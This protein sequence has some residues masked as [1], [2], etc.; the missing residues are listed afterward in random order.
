MRHKRR[1]LKKILNALREPAPMNYNKGPLVRDPQARGITRKEKKQSGWVTPRWPKNPGIGY[2]EA[3]Q[4]ALEPQEFY[5]DW[6]DW[7]DSQRRWYIDASRFKKGISDERYNQMIKKWQMAGH[8]N[9]K[10][11]KE[12]Q[13][14]RAIKYKRTNTTY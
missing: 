12:L 3:I 11:T 8:I 7:R 5:D 14:R 10:L 13:I 2:K 1:L 6:K 9:K 4:E